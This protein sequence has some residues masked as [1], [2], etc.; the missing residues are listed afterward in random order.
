MDDLREDFGA[1]LAGTG[2]GGI[3]D[4]FG[5]AASD[6]LVRV[7][8]YLAWEAAERVWEHRGDPVEYAAAVAEERERLDDSAHFLGW[9]LLS[10]PGLP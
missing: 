3:L 5:N 2:E 4:G 9:L 8:R 6:L 10:A 7:T 1:F